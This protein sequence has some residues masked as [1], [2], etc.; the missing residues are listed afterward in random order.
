MLD[1]GIEAL[2]GLE[3][4]NGIKNF[5]VAETS[6]VYQIDESPSP[7]QSIPANREETTIID[8]SGSRLFSN[9]Q[10]TL[11]GYVERQRIIINGDQSFRIDLSSKKAT[12]IKSPSLASYTA[13]IQKLPHF[14][15]RDVLVERAASLRWLGKADYQGKRQQ[16][17]TFI[18]REGN[19]ASLYFDAQ[20]HLLTRY[21]FMYT[22]CRVG[23]SRQ[24]QVFASYRS[25][26]G[27][28]V[29][30]GRVMRLANEVA[31]DARY[32]KIELNSQLADSLFA[33]P[34][35]IEK[36]SPSTIPSPF[37]VDK[38]AEDVYVIMMVG[39][40]THLLAVAFNDYILVVEAPETR[41]YSRVSEQVIAKIKE[42]IPGKPIKYL[43]FTHHHL[44]HG[45]GARAYIAEGA[46]IV[47]T[48]G[49][50]RFVERLA[51]APFEIMPDA[52]ATGA[53]KP[54][55]EIIEN[56]KRV[57]RDDKHAVELYDVGPWW[58]SD[59]Q[60]IVYLPQHKLL[61]TGDLFG[62]GYTDEVP[63]ADKYTIPLVEKINGLGLEVEKLINSH[64]RHRLMEDFRKSIEKQNR[65]ATNNNRGLRDEE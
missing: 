29:P 56:K 59:E 6:A 60:L 17:I 14:L 51:S 9:I 50:K 49:N 64:S 53:R 48:P 54:V 41:A 30:T 3:A 46:T 22:D 27:L 25:V 7:D 10:S 31:R 8:F 43:T 36:V 16:V 58:E 38:V 11:Q 40:G 19:Q 28:K 42:T 34:D 32:E 55:I 52:L 26:G 13:L 45:C 12:P 62:S 39:G 47:T 44:D 5:T 35:G 61:Y 37:T 1:R 33:L 57:F 4:I 24:E 18:N 20:T 2:G 65:P 63:P 21:E 23:D 15:L